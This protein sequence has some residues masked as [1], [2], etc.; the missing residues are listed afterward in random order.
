MPSAPTTT[1]PPPMM[2]PKTKDNN[3]WA[4]GINNYTYIRELSDHTSCVYAYT[5]PDDNTKVCP[6]YSSQN[7]DWVNAKNKNPG[8]PNENAPFKID[9]GRGDSNKLFF[10]PLI[11]PAP[12]TASP[13]APA[14]T[15]PPPPR[16]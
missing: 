15:T 7:N 8:A 11:H 3:D 13:S 14:T 9:Y 16:K 12:T 6:N 4:S 1:T 10:C 2:C 5:G